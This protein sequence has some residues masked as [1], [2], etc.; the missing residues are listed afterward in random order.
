MEL[1]GFKWVLRENSAITQVIDT[2]DFEE[3]KLG[4][5]IEWE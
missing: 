5:I 3:S 4:G 1:F 2:N